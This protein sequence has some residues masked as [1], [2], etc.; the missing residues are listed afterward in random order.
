M[1]SRANDAPPGDCATVAVHVALPRDQAFEVFTREID[2]W[3]KRGPRYRIAGRRR[4]TLCFE[5]GLGGRLFPSPNGAEP[6]CTPVG[7]H[8]AAASRS[9]GCGARRPIRSTIS[10]ATRQIAPAAIQA[11]V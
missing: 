3:W 6:V 5:E 11:G 10:A 2:L 7:D 9:S 1:M 4:G 8:R